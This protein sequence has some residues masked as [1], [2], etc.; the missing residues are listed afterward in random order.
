MPRLMQ[1]ERWKNNFPEV[2]GHCSAGMPSALYV[3]YF[4]IGETIYTDNEN[5]YVRIKEHSP[6]FKSV[7]QESGGFS[8]EEI[9]SVESLNPDG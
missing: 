7:G 3:P 5:Q 2:K 4:V 8:S 9:S 6:A 1:N